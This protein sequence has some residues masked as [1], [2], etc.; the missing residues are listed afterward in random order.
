MSDLTFQSAKEIV[1]LI[2]SRSATPVEVMEA[3]LAAIDRLNPKLNAIVTL[4]P[5]ALELAKDAEAALMSGHQVGP[6]HGLPVTIKD[7]IETANLRTTSGSRLRE[8]YVPSLDA[9]SVG[10]LK[11]AGAI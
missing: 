9:P 5:N 6:L 1:R 7:T 2:A 3:Q 4:A 8:H 10:L 11:S